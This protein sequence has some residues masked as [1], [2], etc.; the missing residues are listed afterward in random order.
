MRAT[1]AELIAAAQGNVVDGFHSHPRVVS[2]IKILEVP[3]P[4]M[5]YELAVSARDLMVYDLQIA[6]GGAPD[7]DRALLQLDAL[8]TTSFE[9]DDKVGHQ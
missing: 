1:D 9:L 2:A 8:N 5:F 7:D 3:R 4:L 6:G